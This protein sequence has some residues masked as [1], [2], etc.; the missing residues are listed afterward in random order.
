MAE[1]AEGKQ[2]VIPRY[3]Q[4]EHL[5]YRYDL[6]IES[7]VKGRGSLIVRAA[8]GTF[9]L[10]E[11][12]GSAE[13]ISGIARVLEELQSWDPANERILP[14]KEG[15]LWVRDEDGPAY[16]LKTYAGGREC[17]VKNPIEV[18][19]GARKLA[20]LHLAL[21]QVHPEKPE[22]FLLAEHEL[23]EE[24]GRHNRELRNVRN[25]IRKKK[26][27]NEFEE[28]YEKAYGYFYEQAQRIEEY[29]QS[30]RKKADG[31]R[32]QLCHGDYHHHNVF[33]C[34]QRSRVLH[35]E[36][37]RMDQPVADLSKYLRKVLEKNRWNAKLGVGMLAVYERLLPLT[38]DEERQLYVRMAYPEKFWKIANHY[39][40]SKK[41]WASK[42]DGEKLKHLL[43]VEQSRQEFLEILYNRRN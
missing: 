9:M 12:Q 15:E 41:A 20:D 37:M 29:E 25:Y 31:I 2:N 11:F 10:R 21:R 5:L 34:G 22:A 42:R 39:N 36:K 28:M 7:V 14:T 3:G 32:T 17:D 16:L 33:D 19:E 24:I 13:K 40:N 18:M 35:Y 1:C 38:E 27:E 26:K 43:G 8:E 6:E 30:L 4:G 23:G